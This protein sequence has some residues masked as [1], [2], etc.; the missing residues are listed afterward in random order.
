MVFSQMFRFLRPGGQQS[1]AARSGR[2]A[3]SM[4]RPNCKLSVERLEDRTLMAA[5]L[6]GV[7]NWIEQ[8]P[9]PIVGGQTQ[10]LTDNPVTGAVEAIAI[11]PGASG[12][13]LIGTTE[14]G[15]WRTTNINASPVFWTPL[16]DQ[17]PSLAISSIAFSPFD[18][19]NRTLFAG[20]GNFSNG[21]NAGG[22]AVGILK[23]TDLG[24]SWQVIGSARF[25]G[26]RIRRVVP[27]VQT[28]TDGSRVH[29]VL[30]ASTSGLHRSTT[31]GEITAT[32]D[33]WTRISGLA[34]SGLPTGR[35]SDLVADPSTTGSFYCAIP[36][37][38]IF[39]SL[40]FG[41]TW[42]PVNGAITG[43]GA[44]NNIE[45]AVHFNQSTNTRAL[46]AGLVASSSLA[47]VWRSTDNGANWTVIPNAPNVNPGNQG[48]NNF[49]IVA[50]PV[51]SSVVYIGGDRQPNFP[52]V[53]N[54]FEGFTTLNTFVPIVLGGANG[55]APH[56]DTRFMV[57]SGA[58]ILEADD[59]GLYRLRNAN[60]ASRRWESLIGN[61]GVT[62]MVSAAY[63][64]VQN[65]LVAGAQDTGSFNQNAAITDTQANRFRWDQMLGLQGDGAIVDVDTL[66]RN[67]LGNLEPLRYASS[68][69]F[70]GFQ[71][72]GGIPIPTLVQLNV[73]NTGLFPRHLNDVDGNLTPTFDPSLAFNNEFQINRVDSNRMLI[74]T[75]FLYEST[76]RGDHLTSLGGIA[77]LNNNFAPSGS[78]GRVNSIAYGGRRNGV[79]NPDALLVG[80]SGA[81][82]VND[83]DGDGNRTELT[84]FLRAR[85]VGT[86]LPGPR[87]DYE[88]AGGAAILDLVMDPEDDRR[89][90]VLD[91]NNR[92]W[93]GTNINN[94][95]ENWINLTGNLSGLF[96]TIT[97]VGSGA[98]AVPLVGGRAGVF[99][100]DP[101]SSTRFWQEFGAGLPNA[102]VS[103][104]RW[105]ATDD[106]LVA[107]TVGRG[108][109]TISNVS[110][111]IAADPVLL[112]DGTSAN[113]FVRV[114]VDQGNP[115]LLDVSFD[116]SLRSFQAS[117]I[118][119]IVVNLHDGDD[120]LELDG[121]VVTPGPGGPAFVPGGPVFVPGGLSYNGGNGSDSFTS[122]GTA[123][124]DEYSQEPGSPQINNRLTYASGQVMAVTIN[125]TQQIFDRVVAAD[126]VFTAT[127]NESNITL[128][129]G[130]AVG[131]GMLR[132]VTSDVTAGINYAPIEFTG[133]TRLTLHGDA[134]VEIP[135]GSH[136]SISLVNTEPAAGLTRLDV[137]GGF[138]ADT[139]N[140][141]RVSVP[142]TVAG[143]GGAD[144]IN[145]GLAVPAG[146]LPSF[147]VGFTLTSIDAPIT[148]D[149]GAESDTLNLR[150]TLLADG[151]LA[152]T[153]TNQLI[154]GFGTENGGITYSGLEIIN[155][156][157]N[158]ADNSVFVRSTAT[159]ATTNIDTGLG[160]DFVRLGSLGST[161]ASAGGNLNSISFVSVSGRDGTDTLVLDDSG[162]I[163]A[164]TGTL[165]ST[166]ISG[167]GMLTGANYSGFESLTL[168]LG[169][170]ADSLLVSSLAATTS[171]TINSNAGADTVTLGGGTVNN[172]RGPLTINAGG[173]PAGTSDTV[174]LQEAEPAGSTNQGTLGT[175]LNA[176]PGTGF[177]TAF[178]MGAP[179]NFTNTESVRIIEGPSNDF[180]SFQFSSAPSFAITLNLDGG[181]DGVVFHGTD[182]NDRIHISRRVGPGG[183]EVVAQINGLTIV[184]GYQGGETVSVFAGA[185][186]DHVTV[187]ASVTTWRAELFGEDG[188]DHLIG[189]PLGDL[190]D[191]GAGNDRLEGGDGDDELIGGAGHDIFDGGAGAD[192]IHAG[193]GAIDVIFA[194]LADQLLDLDPSDVVIKRSRR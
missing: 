132:L 136:D 138:G 90:W 110:N 173:N 111:F 79:N 1:P 59:G 160:S 157:L 3:S 112:V 151:A 178:G 7:P 186:N 64:P 78:V 61:L 43:L 142:T 88:I 67:I 75:N 36:G 130:S 38:G 2:R 140:V 193:D 17:M 159:G 83:I 12:T 49:S 93:L 21:G 135:F 120:S 86:G 57:F 15:I 18:T 164:N 156:T 107:A 172:I 66:N 69:L 179:V 70:G 128:D 155:L 166:G 56:A 150:A 16:T 80:T 105:D 63:D 118:K 8:G 148:I 99:R 180:V 113:D 194:D 134:F 115:L 11:R 121:R 154:T 153:L 41:A 84:G 182:G 47:S 122:F 185:G 71:R 139:I 5:S 51:D 82:D 13:V 191:G 114:F 37:T 42:Q 171:A 31:G 170:G 60:S 143:G 55:T 149:G 44:T 168:H 94:P 137:D 19:T 77:N 27:A 181:T 177:L 58:D 123:T 165:T 23:S 29:I 158:A 95:S 76:D 72:V 119:R 45:L 129:D 144:E 102:Q 147:V 14:G 190:L 35:V 146:P 22:A 85:F 100:L 62:E 92:V 101:N 28:L 97:V 145:V 169:L 109:W 184:A 39:R 131:D 141:A 48:I 124:L 162:D 30:V 68:E 117:I 26:V 32:G 87:L 98:S 46:Y 108:A 89:A 163:A 54:L 106:V 10:G 103:D 126:M 52:F 187:D 91:V 20:T 74:G 50:D 33:G 40:N 4:P 73:N 188:N 104:L 192:R 81:P 125:A 25:A 183:P 133:K 24:S 65:R 53:G 174:I 9:G 152:G 127:V 96:T 175:P 34:G 6:T 189:G 167:L 161:A 116:G 176:G